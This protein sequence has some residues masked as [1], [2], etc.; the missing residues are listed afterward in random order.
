M[1]L[2]V[3][4]ACWEAHSQTR[5]IRPLNNGRYPECTATTPRVASVLPHG[6]QNFK[7]STPPSNQFWILSNLF[8]IFLSSVVLTKVLFLDFWNF[9][10]LIFN[11]FF[12]FTL[13][14]DGET[15][16][17][18]KTSHRRAKRSE[19]RALWVSIQC[20]QGTFDTS[21]L[22]VILGVIRCISIFQKPCISKTAGLRV[23]DTSRSL[24][25]P[26]YVVIAFYR[27][28]QSAK[29]LGFLLIFEKKTH[30]QFFTISF[31]FCQ[32]GTEWK[33]TFQNASPTP[34]VSRSQLF[35]IFP[36]FSSHKR[37]MAT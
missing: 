35:S 5:Y 14:R 27:V 37:H 15:Y 25:N 22:K 24:F 20:T 13:V 23:K 18:W 28:K 9:Q 6:S 33:W 10:F 36:E 26:V 7:T 8:S 30:F 4:A 32:Q 12:K 16:I 2:Q 17:I 19:I 31:R 11:E 34:P 21:V 1:L 3:P 29:P